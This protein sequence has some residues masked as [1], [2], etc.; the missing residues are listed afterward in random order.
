M[1]TFLLAHF[2][3]LSFVPI[4]VQVQFPVTRTA[5]HSGS[6]S[7]PA[8]PGPPEDTRALAKGY[9]KR[10]KRSSAYLYEAYILLLSQLEHLNT[11]SLANKHTSLYFS[12]IIEE[13]AGRVRGEE[14]LSGSSLF[15]LF[16]T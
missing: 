6:D 14:R 11:A 13:T 16:L 4:F 8:V 1:T 7:Q 12:R 10:L 9:V 2:L 15:R 3:E 5:L